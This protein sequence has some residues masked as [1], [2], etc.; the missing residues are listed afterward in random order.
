M[1]RSSTSKRHLQL[2]PAKIAEKYIS[3]VK[4]EVDRLDARIK[5]VGLIAS[6]DKPSLAYARATQQKFDAIGIDYDLRHI[7]RLDLEHEI[8]SLNADP[9]V[10]GIF[11]YFP[12]FH[13]EQDSY[14]RNLVDYQ[15]DIEAG[16]QYWTRK[17]YANDR[18]A[19]NH[20][21]SRKALLPCT[22]LAI[23]K[24]LAEL[25]LYNDAVD[26]PLNNKTITIFN[27]SEVIGRPLAVMLSNDGARVYS[28]DL[29]GP[30]LFRDAK[31]EELD[32]SRAAALGESDII[33]TGVPSP[34]FDKV[35]RG[36]IKQDSVCLN[37]SSLPNFA[38][39]IKDHPGIYI[40]KVGPMT[41]AMC[42]RNT[43]R[44]YANF[45]QA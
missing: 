42:M 21:P 32:I 24:M 6:D 17:L 15:K 11:I 45:H 9:K 5:V 4:V 3:E 28:F 37:F 36:E 38:D 43:I 35:Q 19:L 14:L 41:V 29:N 16:S 39:D 25:G 27:R 18:L 33:I 30:L 2:D 10:H 7:K 31:P 44:L 13:N 12:V 20:D 1:S 22:P 23:V 8:V 34:Q 26:R 40:A